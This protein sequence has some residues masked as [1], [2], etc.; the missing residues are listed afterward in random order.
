MKL[1]RI[2]IVLGIMA[3]LVWFLSPGSMP[4]GTFAGR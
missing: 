1:R 2:V 4:V 3:L